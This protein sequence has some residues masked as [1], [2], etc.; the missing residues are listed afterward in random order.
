MGHKGQMKLDQ[1]H[2]GFIFS[3]DEEGF[4]NVNPLYMRYTPDARGRFVGQQ[5]YG[6]R[7]FEVFVD[8]VQEIREGAAAAADFDAIL[9]TAT[10][11]MMGTA[12]LEAGRLSLDH[13]NDTFEIVYDKDGVPKDL[14][15]VVK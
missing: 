2:R 12:I 10:S 9:P 1:A 13:D 6:Y 8:A 4:K 14:K 15:R 7:S 3:S 5:G 11:T